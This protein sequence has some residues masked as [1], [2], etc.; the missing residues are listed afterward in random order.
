MDL[1]ETTCMQLTAPIVEQEPMAKKKSEVRKHTAMIR[2]SD[3]AR[4]EAQMAASMLRMSLADYAS[5]ILLKTARKD[6]A[7]VAKKLAN[8][9]K[10]KEP[11]SQTEEMP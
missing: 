9:D 10:M 3:E 1:V 2:V 11:A 5:D 7:C 6:I 4:D 8:R